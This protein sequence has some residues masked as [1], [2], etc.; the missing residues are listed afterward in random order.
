M[1]TKNVLFKIKEGKLDQWK[2]WCDL[3]MTVKKEEALYSLALE[4]VYRETCLYFN[5]NNTTYIIGSVSFLQ[6][7]KPA[8]MTLSV[9]VEHGRQ[10][11]EC[12]E[13]VCN[14]D[15]LYDIGKY[16]DIK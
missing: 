14:I 1:K 7:T 15:T 13:F 16:I 5:I 2:Q 11:K 3:L 10:K 6:D 9:N 4:K 12:L 8:D